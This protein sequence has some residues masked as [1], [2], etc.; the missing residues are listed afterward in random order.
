MVFGADYNLSY[1]N[2]AYLIADGNGIV[3]SPAQ[4]TGANLATQLLYNIV[5]LP[6]VKSILNS[7]GIHAE[8]AFRSNMSLW[9]GYTYQRFIS[10]DWLNA[11]P[12]TAYGNGLLPGDANPSYSVHIIGAS[13]R[14]KW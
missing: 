5:P 6:D 12:A 4:R 7:V 2:T 11:I 13:L 1:G 3:L 9:V 14:Y 8:W 10:N